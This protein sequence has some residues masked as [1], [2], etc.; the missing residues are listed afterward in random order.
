M[1][2]RDKQKKFVHE[3][4]KCF[5]ATKAAELAGYNASNGSLRAIG[6]ENLTKP[7]IKAEID[8][9]FEESAMSAK[10]VL[11]RL[12][13]QGRANM[14]DF[15]HVTSADDLQDVNGELIKKFERTI[16]A[17]SLGRIH[18][19]IK[20][21]LYDGQKA[22]ELIGKHHKVF[23]EKHEVSGDITINVVYEDDNAQ[24]P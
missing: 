11:W 3:Y 13:E 6:S 9:F 5:N 20:I 24:T 7:N 2:L 18:E 10:E 16:T 14:A 21:E 12:S 23:T 17:D 1:A 8:R 15:A 22:L 19:K 4:L